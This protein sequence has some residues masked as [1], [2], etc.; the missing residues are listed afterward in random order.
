MAVGDGQVGQVSTGT[1]FVELLKLVLL[2]L[3]NKTNSKLTATTCI[4]VPLYMLY[5]SSYEYVYEVM[6]HTVISM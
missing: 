5:K 6:T 4:Q 2:V 1:T 3:A